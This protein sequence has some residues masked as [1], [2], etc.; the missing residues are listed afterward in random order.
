MGTVTGPFVSMVLS[1]AYYRSGRWKGRAVV[2]RPDG[3]EDSPGMD[4]GGEEDALDE[5]EHVAP[6]LLNMEG[7]GG[8]CDEETSCKSGSDGEVC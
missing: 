1:Y 3:E 5:T 7:S 2:S 6:I 8:A 4:A